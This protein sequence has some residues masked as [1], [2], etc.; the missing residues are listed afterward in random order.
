MLYMLSTMLAPNLNPEMSF[1]C[2]Q[3]VYWFC[4]KAPDNENIRSYWCRYLIPSNTSFDIKISF[5]LCLCDRVC[6][7]L[8]CS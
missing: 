3:D 7:I 4:E 8:V 6:I 2:D 1:T 5:L